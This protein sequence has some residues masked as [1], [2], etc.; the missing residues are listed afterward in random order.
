MLPSARWQ[1]CHRISSMSWS[2]SGPTMSGICHTTWR[3]SLTPS[4]CASRALSPLTA[5]TASN[6]SWRRWSTCSRSARLAIRS[7]KQSKP[8]RIESG[9]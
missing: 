2:G 1:R 6:G 9:M 4:W 5:Q 8:S 7:P 3:T